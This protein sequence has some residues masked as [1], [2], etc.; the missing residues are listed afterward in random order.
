[1]KKLL[2]LLLIQA[3]LATESVAMHITT[4]MHAVW[5]ALDAA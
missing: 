4:L 3:S 5:E 2:G 1:M